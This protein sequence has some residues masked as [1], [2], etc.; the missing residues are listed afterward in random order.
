[1][2]LSDKIFSC[3]NR[4]CRTDYAAKRQILEQFSTCKQR[5]D[6]HYLSEKRKQLLLVCMKSALLSFGHVRGTREVLSL[7]C[8]EI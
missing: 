4:I 6:I 7:S 2:T 1:M 5:P 3:L 8:T